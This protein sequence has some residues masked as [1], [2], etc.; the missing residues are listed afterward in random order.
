MERSLNIPETDQL[1]W[2]TVLDIHRK[3][4]TLKEEVKSKILE[5]HGVRVNKSEQDTKTIENQIKHL[6]KSIDQAKQAQ[7]GLALSFSNGDIKADVYKIAL[8]NSK[9]NLHNLEVKLAN[10]QLQLKGGGESRKWVEWLRIV[11]E[12][13]DSKK[14]TH[15]K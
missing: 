7:A 5:D 11:G 3:S 8:D 13:L 2:D 9:S 12:S 1:V 14:K 10:L 6:Q 4:S 15:E